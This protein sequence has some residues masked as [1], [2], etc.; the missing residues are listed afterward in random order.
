MGYF[1]PPLRQKLARLRHAIHPRDLATRVKHHNFAWVVFAS[2]ALAML[3]GT[4]PHS[5]T[6]F[7]DALLMR[8]GRTGPGKS[9]TKTRGRK[10]ALFPKATKRTCLW[11]A[12]FVLGFLW[13]YLFHYSV[14]RERPCACGGAYLN[15]ASNTIPSRTIFREFTS[16]TIEK[17]KPLQINTC[18]FF[19]VNG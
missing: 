12:R 4:P 8:N 16:K 14:S 17:T 11:G 3:Y 7:L 18:H 5:P 10:C 13:V 2:C 1:Q 9:C 15:M 19:F 6:R